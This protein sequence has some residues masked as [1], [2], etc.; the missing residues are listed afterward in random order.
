M[1]VIT[2]YEAEYVSEDRRLRK[3]RLRGMKH[4]V[5]QFSSKA[6]IRRLHSIWTIASKLHLLR[7]RD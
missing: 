6:D 2:Q 4:L 3:A 1:R 7:L 5:G